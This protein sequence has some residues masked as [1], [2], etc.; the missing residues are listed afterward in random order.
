M[1]QLFIY[2]DQNLTLELE[3]IFPLDLKN[4]KLT[5]QNIVF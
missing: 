3:K 4:L 5:I 2:G 1:G